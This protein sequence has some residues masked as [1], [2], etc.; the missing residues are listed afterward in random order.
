MVRFCCSLGG[1]SSLTTNVGSR[2]FPVFH[3]PLQATDHS[4]WCCNVPGRRSKGPCCWCTVPGTYLPDN[5]A[6]SG[7]VLCLRQTR[8]RVGSRRPPQR[9]AKDT[10]L[11][12]MVHANRHGISGSGREH[13][14]WTLAGKMMVPAQCG[15]SSKTP[16]NAPKLGGH[17]HNSHCCNRRPSTA[18]LELFWSSS[19]L[20]PR[21]P[22]AAALFAD[23]GP[24]H[25]EFSVHSSVFHLH[26][27]CRYRSIVSVRLSERSAPTNE[28]RQK[29]FFGS[30]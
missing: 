21:T 9:S 26:F 8:T 15:S 5:A 16:I 23:A 18:V 19:V 3:V 22:G 17:C 25:Q 7:G 27:S 4:I 6:S 14:N 28:R 2:P 20:F 1:P 13:W 11:P 30:W 10:S 12:K 29:R 24:S